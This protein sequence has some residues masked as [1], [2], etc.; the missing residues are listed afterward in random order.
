MSAPRYAVYYAPAT[1][2]P[3]WHFGAGWLGWDEVRARPVPQVRLP[4]F[5]P[6]DFHALTGE[7]RRYGFH[8]TLKAPFRLR[9]G[10]TESALRGR[11]AQLAAELHPLPLGQLEPGMLGG[12]VALQPAPRSHEV[13][14]LAARCMLALEDLRA[15]LTEAEIARRRPERLDAVEREL[16]QRHG[17]P[18]VL[19]RF[20][21]HLT[22]SAP[23]DAAT[24]DRLVACAREAVA[25][26]NADHAPVL[27]RLC[28]F[29]EDQA[30]APF[31]RIH[32]E[33]LA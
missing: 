15:P 7:P 18:Y 27:D 29:R 22:L 26:L 16:L 8:A 33:V 20:R 17:Y 2:S 19:E 14:A 4:R 28:L 23:V 12:F 6:D 21:L 13:E 32:D 24:G 11:L 5:S 30:G 3:W 25:P 10:L 31:L 9:E 1:D